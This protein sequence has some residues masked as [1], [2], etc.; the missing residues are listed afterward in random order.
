MKLFAAILL[1]VSSTVVAQ[2]NF[3]PVVANQIN[4]LKEDIEKLKKG[5]ASSAGEHAKVVELQRE[6]EALRQEIYQLRKA[7]F[8]RAVKE[9]RAEA[10]RLYP[11]AGIDGSDFSKKMIEIAD[12]LE[13]EGNQL[14]Y[15]ADA[16]LRIAH[17]A[18]NDLGVAPK[19]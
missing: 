9:S 6:N 14:V 5:A 11:D 13:A 17:M 2:S 18:A 3:D 16:P 8:D 19:Q 12:R 4:N 15:Q 10:V 1:F 7:E